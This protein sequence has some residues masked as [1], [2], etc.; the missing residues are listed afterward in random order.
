MSLNWIFSSDLILN[1]LIN[2]KPASNIFFGHQGL[3]KRETRFTS[4]RPANEIISKI[5]E[6]AMPLGFDV[7][8]NNFKVNKYSL[9]LSKMQFAITLLL[10][11][12]FL[13]DL[14][15]KFI[16]NQIWGLRWGFVEWMNCCKEYKYCM[17]WILISLLVTFILSSVGLLLIAKCRRLNRTD[18]P[19]LDLVIVFWLS[20]WFA[21]KID[22]AFLTFHVQ[23]LSLMIISQCLV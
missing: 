15:R 3:V 17:H 21:N 23:N 14:E 7:K 11:T 4:K 5:E 19:W 1:F 9:F 12:T 18:V 8:K 16:I 20:I 2:M 10:Y 22:L 13:S 6:T